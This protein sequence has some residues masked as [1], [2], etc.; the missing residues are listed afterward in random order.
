MSDSISKEE[1]SSDKANTYKIKISKSATFNEMQNALR[2][3]LNDPIFN[4][5]S[6]YYEYFTRLND[7]EEEV[8]E[9]LKKILGKFFTEYEDK[10]DSESLKRKIELNNL[11]HFID[12]FPSKIDLIEVRESPDFVVT[13]NGEIV[14]IEL[15]GIYDDDVVAQ[16]STLQKICKKVE[17]NLKT[18]NPNAKKLFNVSFNEIHNLSKQQS[19][20]SEKLTNFLQLLIDNKN[21]DLPDFIEQIISSSNEHVQVE[22]SEKYLLKELDIESLTHIIAKKEEKLEQYKRNTN[23]NSQWLLIILEGDS[24]KSNNKL[25]PANLPKRGDN[26]FDKIIIFNPFKRIAVETLSDKA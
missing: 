9:R 3:H 1:K 20:I 12:F 18:Q 4:L 22:L 15:T 13:I 6:E 11:A 23:I 24:E 14:G 7:V 21:D 26:S 25:N 5:T 10:Y 17:T 2:L 19:L 8:G 16:I